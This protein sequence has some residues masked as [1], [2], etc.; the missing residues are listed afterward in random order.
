MDNPGIILPEYIGLVGMKMKIH[1]TIGS[2]RG[3]RSTHKVIRSSEVRAR[4][5]PR[6]AQIEN[7]IS[8][9]VLCFK[10]TI[11]YC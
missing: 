4:D 8:L 6:Q 9:T 2:V 3:H 5:A 7:R 10:N 1:W 11:K